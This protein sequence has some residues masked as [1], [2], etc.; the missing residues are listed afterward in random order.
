MLLLHLGHTLP[1]PLVPV[2]QLGH[3]PL[4]LLTQN[5]LVFDQL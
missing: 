5:F 1:T 2:L 3:H 4:T